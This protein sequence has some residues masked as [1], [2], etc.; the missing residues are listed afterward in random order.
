MGKAST[1]FTSIKIG[2][3]ESR[4]VFVLD[5]NKLC[6]ATY[7]PETPRQTA[8]LVLDFGASQKIFEKQEAEQVYQ[9]L[10]GHPAFQQ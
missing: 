5:V 2:S 4:S 9:A 3:D 8:K 10:S 6:F 1:N 7:K